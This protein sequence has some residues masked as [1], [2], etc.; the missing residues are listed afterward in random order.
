MK[1][2]L[3]SILKIDYLI[4]VTSVAA[5]ICVTFFGV[6]M[7]Y[8]FGAPF[9]WLEEVQLW[10]IV[11]VVFFGGAAAVR[12]GN[13]V[14]IEFIVERFPKNL[15][16]LATFLEFI[17]VSVVLWFLA[18]NSIALILQ[19]IK[20]ERVTNLLHIPYVFI[21]SAVPIGCFLIIINFALLAFEEL[22]GK[23]I[24]E[25]EAGHGN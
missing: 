7:R 22:T 10:L 18:N 11:W 13:H 4:S 24:I 23:Q 16:K 9:V 17:I 6:F 8:V 21:Y 15:H 25:E 1:K 3:N 20:T 19:Y 5:L 12:T 14:A 2:I